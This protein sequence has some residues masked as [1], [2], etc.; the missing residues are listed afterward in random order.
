MNSEHNFSWRYIYRRAILLS[1]PQHR[2]KQLQILQSF[3]GAQSRV[4]LTTLYALGPSLHFLLHTSTL[5]R[6][7]ESLFTL[8][9]RLLDDDL[10]T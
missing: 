6:E 1:T 8:H 3:C 4:Y 2:L 5:V 9:T 7:V 10:S